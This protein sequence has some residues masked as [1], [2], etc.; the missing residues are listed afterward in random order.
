MQFSSIALLKNDYTYYLPL[1]YA[2]P[3]TRP[4]EDR[5]VS[6]GPDRLKAAVF[7]ATDLVRLS[8]EVQ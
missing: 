3:C 1:Q 4:H 8:V 6:G 5:M 7:E 2:R